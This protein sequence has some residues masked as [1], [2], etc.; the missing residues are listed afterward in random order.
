MDVSADALNDP[1]NVVIDW[2]KCL[3]WICKEQEMTDKNNCS[4][5]NNKKA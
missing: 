2:L 5:T 4:T 1:S 3:F